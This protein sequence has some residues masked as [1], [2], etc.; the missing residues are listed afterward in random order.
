MGYGIDEPRYDSIE[1]KRIVTIRYE[2]VIT[3][4]IS[5]MGKVGK[6]KDTMSE[7]VNRIVNI[8]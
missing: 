3:G 2:S 6:P 4:F 1:I 8:S 5:G 7:R